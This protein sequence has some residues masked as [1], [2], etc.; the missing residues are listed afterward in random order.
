M[1][2]EL[3]DMT[4]YEALRILKLLSALESWAF[5]TK[6]PLPP[7]VDNELIASMEVLEK[8]VLREGK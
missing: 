5:S 4:K 6:N 1:D 7:F 8:I 3:V 2:L